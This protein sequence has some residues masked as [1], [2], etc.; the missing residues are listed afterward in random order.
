[1]NDDEAWFAQRLG[2]DLEWVLAAGLAQE[3]P[4]YEHQK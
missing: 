4:W 1:L 3:P 2:A